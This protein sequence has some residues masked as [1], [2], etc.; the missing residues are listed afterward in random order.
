MVT[1]QSHDLKIVGSI[2]ISGKNFLEAI[3]ELW[4][5]AKW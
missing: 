1:R 3:R 5:I 4:N 2:P